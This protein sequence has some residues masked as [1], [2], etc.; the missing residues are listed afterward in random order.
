MPLENLKNETFFEST[1]DCNR[2]PSNRREARQRVLLR[3][4]IHAI[5]RQ[6]DIRVTD[7]SRSGMRGVT[8]LHLGID[9]SIFVSL[10]DVTHCLGNVRWTQDRRVGVKFAQRLEL[11]P[12]NLIMDTGILPSHWEQAPQIVRN[13]SAKITLSN[14]SATA[15]IRNISKSGMMIETDMR[16]NADKQL[17]ISLSNGKILKALVKWVE[18]D[19][20]G[21]Q[22]S[23]PASALQFSYDGLA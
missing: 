18:G 23:S 21:V 9:Q 17:L 11:L 22:L 6:G 3:A 1:I 14:A 5:D 4:H 20:V 12:D 15:R 8:D 19:R 7:L 16:L 10:D 2:S 13:F